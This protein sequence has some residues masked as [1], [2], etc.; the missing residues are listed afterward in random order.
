MN[1]KGNIL[2][3]IFDWTVVAILVILVIILLWPAFASLAIDISSNFLA[4]IFGLLFLSVIFGVASGLG[5]LEN[6]TF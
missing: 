3:T 2:L 1:Q 5:W 4:S 6:Q